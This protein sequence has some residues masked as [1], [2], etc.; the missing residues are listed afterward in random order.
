MAIVEKTVTVGELRDMFG[1]GEQTNIDVSSCNVSI[2]T[3]D[4][5]QKLTHWFNKGVLE[6]VRVETENGY[7]S[8][9]AV[10][11]MLQ[12]EDG[13][14]VRAAYSEGTTILTENGPSLVTKV[15]KIEDQVC[16]DFTVDHDNHRYFGD[17]MSSHNSGKSFLTSGN[18]AA[19]AQ[20]KGIFVVLIDTE[21][22]LD[23]DWLHALGVDTDPEKLL[24]LNVAMVDDVAKIISEFVKNYKEDYG[25]MPRDDRPKVLFIIDSLGMMLVPSDVKQFEGGD[26]KGDMG[27]KAKALK[28]LVTNCV[29]TFG[30]LD[31]GLVATNHSYDSQDMFSPDP[32]ISG[33]QGFVYASSIVIAMRKNKL[34]EDTE[35]NKTSS[36]NGI[37]S[38]IKV[39][40]TRYNKPFEECKLNIP[41]ET[42]LDPY[43]GL[44]D[45]FEDRGYF[46]K[47]GNRLK[48]IDRKG[49]EHKYFRKAIPNELLDQMMEE[50]VVTEN[51]KKLSSE[52]ET[53]T[54][55]IEE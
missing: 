30:E 6:M 52:S 34:K 13:K 41:Y 43:S 49:E 5:W 15:S 8:E 31:I 46:K 36:V 14:W 50:F 55:E 17:G 54:I 42:G 28:A 3:P 7:V 4:G 38:S 32:K 24:K 2:N 44:I 16:Y 20:S 53:K 37:R 45:F 23:E 19:D 39:I 51:E 33:G 48:Y 40:K 11:H 35:G 21:N 1:V 25:D 29:N 22:A 26:M 47:D 9:C 27:R 18:I 12:E 10:N